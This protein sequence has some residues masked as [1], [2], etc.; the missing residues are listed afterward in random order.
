MEAIGL[1]AIGIYELVFYSCMGYVLTSFKLGGEG[2]HVHPR[3]TH[4]Q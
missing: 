4:H 2:D 3:N 1:R